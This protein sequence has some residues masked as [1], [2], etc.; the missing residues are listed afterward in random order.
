MRPTG[1][2]PGSSRTAPSRRPTWPSI[3]GIPELHS[4]VIDL[5]IG[6]DRYVR[7]KQAIRKIENGGRPAVTIYEV[8][9]TFEHLDEA[10]LSPGEHP[11]DQKNPP[12]PK[13]Y[14]FLKLTPKTGRTHQLRVHMTAIGFPMVGDTMYGGHD[15]PDWATSA[16]N[17]RPCTRPRSPSPIPPRWSR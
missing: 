8:L 12:P 11:K 9:Q 4:D 7:E 16:S 14:A 6:K 3:H 10:T 17:A 15:L 5:P 13:K 2:W 1:G